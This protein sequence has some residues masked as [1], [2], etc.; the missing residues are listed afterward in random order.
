MSAAAVLARWMETPLGPMLA[1]VADEGLCLLEFVDRRGL[2]R[3]L[4]PLRRHFP[5]A[6]VPGYHPVLDATEDQVRR[7]FEGTLTAFDLPLAIRG[8]EFER[9]VWSELVAIPWGRTRSYADIARGVGRP[10][11][12]RAV[13]RA[14]GAN[15]L[16]LVVPC[17]RVV[18]TDGSLCGYGGGVWRKEWLLAHEGRSPSLWRKA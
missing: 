4:V 9:A 6:V 8:S 7:Y 10:G 1:L 15:R 18:R 3:E 5:G 17:H 16:C 14:N 13:G 2:E 12:S 11:A